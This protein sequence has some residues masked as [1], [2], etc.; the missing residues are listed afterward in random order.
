M[1]NEAELYRAWEQLV[2]ELLPT[3]ECMVVSDPQRDWDGTL[4]RVYDAVR[5]S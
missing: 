5:A 4:R 3:V 2:D 1:Q